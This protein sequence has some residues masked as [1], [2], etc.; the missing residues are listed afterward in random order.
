MWECFRL[1]FP[2]Q[3]AASLI[4]WPECYNVSKVLNFGGMW[5]RLVLIQFLFQCGRRCQMEERRE[6]V[7]LSCLTRN[8]K[9]AGLN[10]I[11]YSTIFFFI[12]QFHCLGKITTRLYDTWKNFL[13]LRRGKCD[14][15]GPGG[16]CFAA[17]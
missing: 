1:M 4:A 7:V 14:S 13:C 6:F 5:F 9:A 3:V 15:V 10:K 16:N 12:S 8:L 17:L 11:L 2:R